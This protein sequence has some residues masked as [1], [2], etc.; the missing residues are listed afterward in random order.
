VGADIPASMVFKAFAA[1]CASTSLGDDERAFFREARPCGLILFQRNCESP[2]Q[3]RKLV[4][5][6]TAAVTTTDDDPFLVLVDQEGGRVRRLRP[7]HWRKFP[8][9]RAFG[10]LHQ[11]DRESGLEAARLCARLQAEDLR[12]SCITVNCA[13]VLDIPVPGSHDIIG[14]RAYGD[15]PDCIIALARSVAEGYMAGGVVPVIKHVPGHGRARADSHVSLPVI[16]TPLDQLEASDF[17]PFAALSDMPAAMT[18]HLLMMALDKE[19]PVSISPV[20]VEQV[21]RKALGFDGLLMS[22]DLSMKALEGTLAERATGVISAGCDI[23]LHCNGNLIEMEQVAA[24]APDL[25]EYSRIRLEKVYAV[26]ARCEPYD[27]PLAE[28]YLALALDAEGE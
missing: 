21:I 5:D 12:A 3:I 1:G 26:T 7:P 20:I 28:H 23:A 13:P 4:E 10:A 11:Q 2:D 24:V 15:E 18:A 9:A 27:R 8:S 6:A 22:D 25:S 16:E 17:K 14:D 19:R